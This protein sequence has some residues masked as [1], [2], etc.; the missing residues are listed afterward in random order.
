MTVKQFFKST[1]FKCIAVLTGVLLTSGILLAIAFGFLE[2]TDEERFNRKIGVMYGGETVTSQAQDISDKNVK[3]KGATIEALWLITNKSD[4]LVQAS[5]RGNGGDVT[6][7][8]TINMNG[9]AVTG[10]GKVLL[11][12]VDDPAE[13]KDNIGNDIYEKFHTEYVEGKDFSYGTKGT[14]D[15]INTGASYTLSAVCNNVNGAVEF[16]KAYASGG[17]IVKDFSK[18]IDKEKTS[19]EIDGETVIYDIYTKGEEPGPFHFTIKVDA[20]GTLTEYII[21]T[22]GSSTEEESGEDYGSLMSP[23]AVN[24]KGKTLVDIESYLDNADGVLI[25]GATRSNQRCYEAAAY[26]LT[27]YDR[28]MNPDKG[29]E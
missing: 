7:W 3:V 23:Q 22:N 15:Y 13:F 4:Y 2:V 6:C 20:S 16:V 12:S 18:N 29:G 28:I 14:E 21:L 17:E 11:Y 19:W 8:I 24:L 26:A 5:S 25:T 27:E 10:I 9:T 1:A